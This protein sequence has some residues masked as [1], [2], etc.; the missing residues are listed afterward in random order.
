MEESIISS[1]VIR[2][3]SL[4]SSLRSNKK[5]IEVIN[6][7]KDHQTLKTSLEVKIKTLNLG[8]SNGNKMSS[9]NLHLSSGKR[10]KALFI[11]IL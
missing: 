4:M 6:S 8:N 2:E 3:T 10:G 7:K 5:L 9:I 11:E 1:M